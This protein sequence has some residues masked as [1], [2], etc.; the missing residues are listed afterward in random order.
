[1]RELAIAFS[2]IFSA[3]IAFLTYCELRPRWWMRVILWG[4]AQLAKALVLFYRL[5]DFVHNL[6]MGR[7]GKIQ[8][9]RQQ[10]MR[11]RYLVRSAPLCLVLFDCHHDD[12]YQ[13]EGVSGLREKKVWKAGTTTTRI[14]TRYLNAVCN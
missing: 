13:M 10:A 12:D 5:L 9:T 7:T 3:L 6:R 1:M 11:R 8:L 4:K 14:L 2:V